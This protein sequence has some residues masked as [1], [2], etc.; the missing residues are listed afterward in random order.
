MRVVVISVCKNE[1][2]MMPHFIRHYREVADDFV[3]FDNGSTDGTLDLIAELPN[4]RVIPFNALGYQKEEIVTLIR[5]YAYRVLPLKADWCLIVD[6]DE[7][8]CHS[9]LRGYLKGC[10]ERGVT[11]PRVAGF[12]MYHPQFPQDDGRPLTEIITRGMRHSFFCK[13]AAVHASVNIGYYY[14]AHSAFPSGAVV[15]SEE[16]EL[17]LRHYR[18]NQIGYELPLDAYRKMR[19]KRFSEQTARLIPRDQSRK[20]RHMRV[21]EREEALRYSMPVIREAYEQEFSQVEAAAAQG[22]PKALHQL[23]MLRYYGHFEERNPEESLPF[24]EK[25][26]SAGNAL[27][28]YHMGCEYHFGN[29]CPQDHARAL[30]YF[31]QAAQQGHKE[32]QNQLAGMALE[33]KDY[34]EAE[35]WLLA[36]AKQGCAEAQY[37]L[38]QMY[39]KDQYGK[40][41]AEAAEHWLQQAYDQHLLAAMYRVGQRAFDAKDY[42]NAF[43]A[44]RM[45]AERSQLPAY[46][47]V[48]NILNADEGPPEDPQGAREFFSYRIL[49]AMGPI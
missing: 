39:S 46:E 23:G 34:A 5:N 24:F 48:D 32:A 25:A 9:D 40:C 11:L 20:T 1:A 18:L 41:D 37:D 16:C 26:A 4:A 8:L 30:G 45:A 38:F 44:F 14:G 28:Q 19:N 6:T 7:F 35:R 2:L 42:V 43:K 47:T 29:H 21:L 12:N 31:R 33:S 3:F 36:A 15:Y 13:F 22:D 27:A 49:R 10:L 17:V